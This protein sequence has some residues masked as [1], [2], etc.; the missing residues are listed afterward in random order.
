[1]A[2]RPRVWEC[3]GCAAQ[4]SVTSGTVMHRSKVSLVEWFLA[5]W[6]FSQDKRGVSAL[7]LSKQLGRR[8]ETVWVLLHKLRAALQEDDA[9]FPLRGVVEADESYTGGRTTGGKRGRSLEDRRRSLVAVAVERRPVEGRGVRGSGVCCGSARFAVVRDASAESLG[10]FLERVCAK[11]TT[12]L[13]DGLPSYGRLVD[14]GLVPQRVVVGRPERASVVLPLVHTLFGNLQAWLLGTF[15]GVSAKWLPRYV[16]EFGWRF[17]RRRR[18]RTLW[19]YLLRR[20]VRKPWVQR[21]ELPGVE[22]RLQLYRAA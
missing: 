8:Y 12:V 5:A 17:N 6:C 4:V 11:G 10:T 13:C 18:E 1:M 20:C 16:Q 15:H 21:E 19:D 9:A 22:P 7:Q 14:R 3:S 2:V